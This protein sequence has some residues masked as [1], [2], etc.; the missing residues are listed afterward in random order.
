MRTSKIAALACTALVLASG[1]ACG[2]KDEA[3][4]PANNGGV[5][6]ESKS[7]SGG[8]STTAKSSGDKTTTTEEGSDTTDTTSK[9]TKTTKK[10]TTTE[11]GSDTTDL[12]IP[13]VSIPD[14]SIPGGLPGNLEEC[15]NAMTA[16]SS[17]AAAATAF[18]QPGTTQ[19]DVDKLNAQIE[20]VKKGLP[21]ELK[22][23]IEI[24]AAAYSD[25]AK[26]LGEIMNN[27]GYTN[28]DNLDKLTKASEVFD[29]SGFKEAN[30]RIS[31]YFEKSCK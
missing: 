18:M 26:T 23:D 4:P 24:W 28:P 20:E 25:Y 6:A 30:D 13:D 3:T 27:G 21:E 22:A 1:L 11:D 2:K 29:E 12:S 7:S 16:F 5:I 10:T 8:S 31:A 17:V 19:E 14:V 9:T 15:L